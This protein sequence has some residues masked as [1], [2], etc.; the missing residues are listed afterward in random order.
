MAHKE[1]AMKQLILGIAMATALIAGTT[2]AQPAMAAAAVTAQP[3]PQ[4]NTAQQ[5]SPALAP[6]PATGV[7]PQ[8]PKRFKKDGLLIAGG[9][10]VVAIALAGA[11]GSS[12]DHAS[13]P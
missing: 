1:T 12:H 4:D 6:Q 7:A 13:S 11:G 8:N 9:I 3:Q 2:F 10:A 5:N